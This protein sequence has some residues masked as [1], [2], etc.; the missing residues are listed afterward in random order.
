VRRRLFGTLCALVFLVNFGRVAFA[1]LVEPLQSA[2]GVGPA[3]IGT[4]VSLA[5]LGT[6]LSR[7]PTGYLL[8]RV[9]RRRVVLGTGIVL[10][11]SAGF[12]ATATSI[13]ALQVGAF[14]VGSTSGAYFVA[15]VPF[16]RDLVPERPGRAIGIHGT[17]A[18]VAAVVAPS[19]VFGVLAVASWREAFWLLAAA[20]LVVTAV[21]YAVDGVETDET[22]GVDTDFLGAVG[23]WRVILTGI[24]LVAAAGFVWQGLFNFYVSFLVAEKGL[25]RA[26]AGTALTV[27]FAAGLP[28]FY[29]GGRLAD[30]LPHV[31]YVLVTLGVYAVGVF[32]VTYVDGFVPIL[33]ATAVV[34][35]TLYSLFPA[36][37][38]YVLEVLPAEHRASAY[39]LFSGVSLLIES[40]GSGAVGYLTEA[41]YTFTVVFRGFAAGMGLV[42]VVLVAV[43]LAGAM[44]GAS[45][46]YRD[47]KEFVVR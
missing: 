14:A 10:A 4:V 3:T 19:V 28:A 42:V 11:G 6:A 24:A 15:A 32:A 26:T 31:P 22:G 40:G 43:Y 21:F 23:E 41:G 39:A 38:T 1:P 7:F 13:P 46:S 33:V 44:P 36:L 17:A 27:A 5:W 34:G 16:I 20:S 12:T 30:R 8:T 45:P 37:D 29:L 47:V 9:S 2:F 18:Q 25:T 35:Y